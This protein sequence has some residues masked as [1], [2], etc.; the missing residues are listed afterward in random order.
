MKTIALLAVLATAAFGFGPQTQTSKA[1][2]T[3]K[4]G[5]SYTIF[6]YEAPK[7]FAIQRK[8]QDSAYWAKWMEYIGSVQN[9]GVMEGGSGLLPPDVS[10][11]I[12]ARGE[13]KVDEQ[14]LQLGGYIV[15]KANSIQ[16]AAAIAR[17][18]PAVADGGRVEVRENLPAD[19]K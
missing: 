14:K 9:S 4:A 3:A 2:L 5:K 15:V 7:T 1:P 19:M 8:Q 18:S 6:F 11:Q 12:D 16:E 17:K 10:V 13:R